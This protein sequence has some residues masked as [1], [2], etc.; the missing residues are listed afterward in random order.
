LI[1]KGDANEA[2]DLSPVDKDRVVGKLFF[3][4]PR[5]GALFEQSARKLWI[6][7]SVCLLLLNTAVLLSSREVKIQEKSIEEKEKT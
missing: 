7:F 5:A 2:E 4:V 6:C 3:S 1:T